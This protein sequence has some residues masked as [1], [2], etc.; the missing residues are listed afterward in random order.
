MQ[1]N[2]STRT[3]LSPLTGVAF[4]AIAITGILMFF[5]VRLPGMILLHE[6]GGLLF[7]VVAVLHLRINWR[8]LLSCCRQ[9]RGRIALW[10]GA[11]ITVVLLVLGFG[12]EPA[13]GRHRGPPAAGAVDIER[14]R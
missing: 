12:H 4:L 3:W 1:P 11:A 2:P 7:V 9:R 5:H 13:H 14:G 10:A 8:S 6:L